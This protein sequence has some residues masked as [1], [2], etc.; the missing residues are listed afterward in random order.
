MRSVRTKTA[1]VVTGSRNIDR[2]IAADVSRIIVERSRAALFMV[3]DAHGFDAEFTNAARTRSETLRIFR[4]N[5]EVADKNYRVTSR[6]HPEV[7]GFYQPLLRN[8]AMADA[9]QA[10]VRLGWYCVGVALYGGDRRTG[11]TMH[12]VNRLRERGIDTME[13]YAWNED[14]YVRVENDLASSLDRFAGA[15]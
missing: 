11:G 12:T 1:V 8:E 15:Q 10:L 4:C 5:G 7:K 14:I 9:A 2:Y 3:G 6:W 13:F